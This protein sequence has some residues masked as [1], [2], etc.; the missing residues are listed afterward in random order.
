[1]GWRWRLKPAQPLPQ[2]RSSSNVALHHADLRWPHFAAAAAATSRASS[3]LLSSKQGCIEIS[4]IFF[5]WQHTVTLKN[6][7]L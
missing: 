3:K 5:S 2:A 7:E 4:Q 6:I 1:V